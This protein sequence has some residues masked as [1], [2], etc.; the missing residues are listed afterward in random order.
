MIFVP[1]SCE[2]TDNSDVRP[3]LKSPRSHVNGALINLKLK[4]RHCSN[5]VKE[6]NLCGFWHDGEAAIPK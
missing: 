2:H 3:G 1:V 6:T 5:N 4:R